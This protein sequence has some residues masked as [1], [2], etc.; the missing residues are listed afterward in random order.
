[1]P[2]LTDITCPACGRVTTLVLPTD[3]DEEE[4]YEC[5]E[6]QNV[7]PLSSEGIVDE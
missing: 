1:M 3:P 4:T 6:C 5:V 2:E 7:W